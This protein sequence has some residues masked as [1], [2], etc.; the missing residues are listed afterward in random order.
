[1][2]AR[3]T[4]PRLNQTTIRAMIESVSSSSRPIL[5]SPLDTAD[6]SLIESF[7]PMPRFMIGSG[8]ATHEASTLT[9]E[10]WLDWLNTAV[11]SATAQ[12]MRRELALH[13]IEISALLPQSFKMR[14]QEV[15]PGSLRFGQQQANDQKQATSFLAGMTEAIDDVD[16]PLKFVTCEGRAPAYSAAFLVQKQLF[17]E[18]DY[19]PRA[20]LEWHSFNLF[21]KV[22][23]N[24]HGR[25][26]KTADY[27]DFYVN[28]LSHYDSSVL[29]S[30]HCGTTMNE[31]LKIINATGS[32]AELECERSEVTSS[33]SRKLNPSSVTS[34]GTAK[35]RTDD[36]GGEQR[37][38]LNTVIGL[39]PFWGG[40]AEESK[41]NAHS[42][43]PRELKTKQAAGT[44]CSALRF[45]RQA[46]IGVCNKGDADVID[47]TL[48]EHSISTIRAASP[49]PAV[50]SEID[51]YLSSSDPEQKVL[52]M[53]EHRKDKFRGK[54]LNQN[55][56]RLQVLISKDEETSGAVDC[57][58][59]LKGS[60]QVVIAEL[61]CVKGVFLPYLLLERAQNCLRKGSWSHENVYFTE[62]DQITG[63]RSQRIGKALVA[64]LGLK[65]YIA[66]Q[67]MVMKSCMKTNERENNL[68][69]NDRPNR[70]L[71][72]ENT[73]QN[74]SLRARRRR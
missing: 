60:V 35:K 50:R 69:L 46:A 64:K 53:L 57:K 22:F 34:K 4:P 66:P 62:A 1:M 44:I 45:F 27:N 26:L 8:V 11:H 41:G 39:V 47:R 5:S 70:Q 52:A 18:V 55:E 28:H 59:F 10:A 36:N 38:L 58:H 23:Y 21:I 19:S 33:R 43:A 30:G 32:A 54:N 37:D 14:M 2:P 68:P 48:R 17:L 3:L 51:K 67:R 16:R 73:C 72:L 7:L 49:S 20:T 31:R 12:G 63:I 25:V 24:K 42:S 9:T 29:K 61:P 65:T 71:L 56:Q 74:K 6:M 15:T 13:G 40:S